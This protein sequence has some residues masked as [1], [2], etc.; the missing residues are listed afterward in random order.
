M[1][2]S[3]DWLL[4]NQADVS[5]WSNMSSCELVSVCHY[6]IFSDAM[7]KKDYTYPD[8]ME[9]PSKILYKDNTENV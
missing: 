7:T 8:N 6:L 4:R 2:L 3:K 9:Q 1:S 5:E